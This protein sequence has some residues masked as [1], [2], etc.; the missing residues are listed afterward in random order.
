MMTKLKALELF[1]GIG[2]FAAAVAGTGTRVVGAL[3]QS[4]LALEVYRPHARGLL[5]P[6]R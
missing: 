2:G 3:D 5:P 6:L 4:P 1:C